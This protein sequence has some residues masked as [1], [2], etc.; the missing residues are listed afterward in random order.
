[1]NINLDDCKLITAVEYCKLTNT[2]FVGQTRVDENMVYYMCWR[3]EGKLYK[4]K[5]I[6]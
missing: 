3:S 2:E 5:N 1:M 6:L 4:T